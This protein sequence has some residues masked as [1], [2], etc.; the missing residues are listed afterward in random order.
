MLVVNSASVSSSA[1][2]WAA[3]RSGTRDTPSPTTGTSGRSSFGTG[4][5][6]TVARRPIGV[7]GPDQDSVRGSPLGLD[8]LFYSKP[9]RIDSIPLL[10]DSKHPH[11]IAGAIGTPPEAGQLDQCGAANFLNPAW[12][13]H[14]ESA[15]ARNGGL[16]NAQDG[17]LAWSKEIGFV[18][19]KH[20]G[21]SVEQNR[22]LAEISLQT[23][24]PLEDLPTRKSENGFEDPRVFDWVDE[25]IAKFDEQLAGFVADPVGDALVV[26]SGKRRYVL[27]YNEQANGFVSYEYKKAGGLR[28]FAQKALKATGPA[29]DALSVFGHAIPGVG[30]AVAMGAR[31]VSTVG[32]ILATGKLRVQQIVGAAANFLFPTG[33]SNATPKQIGLVGAS[34]VLAEAID[35]GKLRPSSLVSVIS[36]LV[37]GVPGGE[38]METAVKQGLAIVAAGAEGRRISASDV[39]NA[40]SPFLKDGGA[41]DLTARFGAIAASIVDGR[42][43]AGSVAEALSPALAAATGDPRLDGLLRATLAVVAESV[44]RSE[45]NAFD[46]VHAVTPWFDAFSNELRAGEDASVLLRRIATE[47]GFGVGD[48]IREL[49]RRNDLRS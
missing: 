28:G 45:I 24:F 11:Y 30:T 14:V 3:T 23:G 18:R 48:V 40:L 35:T 17:Y 42:F 20:V 8:G 32:T 43:S 41:G 38:L 31:A 21:F 16:G 27:E 13:K 34:N 25:F 10:H 7:P 47:A 33:L 29:L 15:A 26:K 37:G 22:R 44:D 49:E 19:L 2:R 12:R 6:A 4:A 46:F 1:H 5:V 39:V 36:P 9:V